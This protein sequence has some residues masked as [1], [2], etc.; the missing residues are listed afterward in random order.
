MDRQFLGAYLIVMAD[1]LDFSPANI[2]KL[3]EMWSHQSEERRCDEVEEGLEMVS[4]LQRGF[5]EPAFFFVG[6]TTMGHP[7]FAY[8]TA[9]LEKSILE[10]AFNRISILNGLMKQSE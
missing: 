9:L 10:E 4:L 7:Y 8:K 3:R 6:I 1:K 5:V 2:I